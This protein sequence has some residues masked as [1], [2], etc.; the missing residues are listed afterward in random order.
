MYRGTTPTITFTI[1]TELNLADIDVC[2]ITFKSAIGNKTKEFDKAHTVIDLEEKTLTV[3]FSQADTLLFKQGLV[4]AQIRL[5]LVDG[6]TFAS[7]I[8]SVNVNRILK[9]GII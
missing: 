1:N 4:D 9:D 8:K 6:R 7:D 3:S 5:R 2:Y